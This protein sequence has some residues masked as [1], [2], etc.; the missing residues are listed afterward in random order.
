MTKL[1]D[2]A[3]GQEALKVN[4]TRPAMNQGRVEMSD[5]QV[6]LMLQDIDDSREEVVQLLGYVKHETMSRMSSEVILEL[7]EWDIDGKRF[8]EEIL[9]N[10]NT[11]E[12]G[13]LAGRVRDH[14]RRLEDLKLK[15]Q[16]LKAPDAKSRPAR[17]NASPKP[18]REELWQYMGLAELGYN[19]TQIGKITGRNESTVRRTLARAGY[20][21]AA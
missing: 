8:L 11:D 17:R 7:A 16:E 4:S 14:D 12:D 3:S 1:I 15:L 13:Y 6:E 18:A 20:K 19:N 5:E 21:G 10:L 9:T 2:M